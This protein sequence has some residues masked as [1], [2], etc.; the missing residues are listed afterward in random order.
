MNT[1]S[2]FAGIAAILL[3]VE[4]LVGVIVAGA[5][6]YFLRRGLIIGQQKAAP[7]VQ[8]A[9]EQIQRVEELTK[10][11]SELIVGSQVEAIST[12]RGLRQ[13]LRALLH[14]TRSGGENATSGET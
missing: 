5:A 6:I 4:L 14:E 12:V 1:I 2:I 13:G 7:Y 10:E 8:Q 9:T 3:I 11:Y